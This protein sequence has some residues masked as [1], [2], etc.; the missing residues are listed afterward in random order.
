MKFVSFESVC[1]QVPLIPCPVLGVNATGLQPNCYSRS[2][3]IFGGLMFETATCIVHI[4]AFVMVSIMLYHVNVK[5]TAVGKREMSIFLYFYLV[6]AFLEVLLISGAIPTASSAYPWFAALHTGLM[7]ATTWSLLLNGFIGFQFIED[8]TALTV[9]GIRGSSGVIALIT[10]IVSIGTFHNISD[11]L[12]PDKPT[13]LWV[14]YFVLNGACILVYFILQ[15]ILIFSS[16]DNL[17]PLGDITFALA[18][19][20]IGQ[21]IQSIFSEQICEMA[22]HYLDGMFFS[23]LCTLLGV[24]MVYK[25]WDSITKEDL[26]FSVGGRMINWEVKGSYP[27]SSLDY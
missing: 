1:R 19:F 18:F 13:G 17:W 23:A 2:I 27:Q 25:Y 10:F 3:E 7:C 5:Y 4:V 12:N 15:V 16:L 8:G 20:L 24:M 14:L 6:S 22:K 21:L 26:E 11:A 9:W